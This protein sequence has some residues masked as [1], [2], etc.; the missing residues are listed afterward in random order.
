MSTSPDIGANFSTDIGTD[1]IAGSGT[2]Y[3]HAMDRPQ[4]EDDGEPGAGFSV[5]VAR[6]WERAQADAGF[7]FTYPTL[8]PALDDILARDWVAAPE[9]V[10]AD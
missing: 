8:G 3:R 6:A 9:P 4:A 2:I 1:V 7:R 10:R 5:S